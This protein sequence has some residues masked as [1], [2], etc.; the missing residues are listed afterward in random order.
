MRRRVSER[1][2]MRMRGEDEGG[3]EIYRNKILCYIYR[4]D[5]SLLLYFL[6]VEVTRDIHI[7][8]FSLFCHSFTYFST[9]DIVL[10]FFLTLTPL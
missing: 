1:V 5:F 9:S 7:S 3:R 2:R 8:S 4:F 10:N 6:I